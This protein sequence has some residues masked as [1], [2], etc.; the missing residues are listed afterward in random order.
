MALISSSCSIFSILISP[1]ATS[2]R[3]YSG[4][5]HHVHPVFTSLP[6]GQSS[7][8]THC[9]CVFT[10]GLLAVSIPRSRWKLP[11]IAS[12][13]PKITFFNFWPWLIYRPLVSSLAGSRCWSFSFWFAASTLD[14][15]ESVSSFVSGLS[16]YI[17]EK[18]VDSEES[19]YRQGL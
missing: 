4:L 8:P 7:R 19:K 16:F 1:S 9:T 11:I 18:Q 12:R 3:C 14:E 10:P 6:R 5:F 2:P 15:I 17:V 13:L